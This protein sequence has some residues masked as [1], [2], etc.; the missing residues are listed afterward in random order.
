[1]I[2]T[3][4]P[5]PLPPLGPRP[6]EDVREEW[7]LRAQNSFTEADRCKAAGDRVGA[8]ISEARAM[9]YFHAWRESEG[10]TV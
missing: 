9:A 3:K 10:V 7:R 6:L 5:N 4:Q 1:M 2:D 8:R